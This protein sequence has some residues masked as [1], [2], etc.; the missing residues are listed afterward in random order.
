MTKTQ[1]GIL[2]M[3]PNVSAFAFGPLWSILCDMFNA[4]NQV[5]LMSIIVSAVLFQVFSI[6]FA[7]ES[8]RTHSDL[9]L[10]HELSQYIH[11]DICYQYDRIF[12]SSADDTTS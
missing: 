3:I 12:L 6:D 5:M 1:I 4:H 10:D 7:S 11:C 9:I 8:Y 2:T